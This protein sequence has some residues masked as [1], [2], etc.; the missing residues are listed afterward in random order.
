MIS[1]L[2]T[3]SQWHREIPINKLLILN[4][5][6]FTFVFFWLGVFHV[7]NQINKKSFQ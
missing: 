3:I 2:I 6:I 4:I 1:G 7:R 5:S